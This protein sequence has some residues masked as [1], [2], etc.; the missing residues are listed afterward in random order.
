MRNNHHHHHNSWKPIA[1]ILGA[2]VFVGLGYAWGRHS[3]KN[4]QEKEALKNNKD[5]YFPFNNANL[6]LKNE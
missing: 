4:K 6:G 2:I 5:N 3:E 1:L